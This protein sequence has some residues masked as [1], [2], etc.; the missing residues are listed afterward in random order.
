M[1][2]TGQS[3]HLIG[4][5]KFLQILAFAGAAG[6]L[7]GYGLMRAESQPQVVR[8]SRTL[9]GTQINLIVYGP[10]Q[11]QCLQATAA[12]FNRME[13]LEQV[14]SRHQVNSALSQ[15]NAQGSLMEAPDALLEVLGL[16]DQISRATE[17]AFDVSV[18]PLLQLYEKT[19]V[20]SVV[21]VAEVLPLV[22]YQKIRREGPGIRLAKHG[23]AI[24]L[25]GIAK[26]YIV[27]QG[28]AALRGAGFSNVYVEA[29][30]D[31]MVSGAKP[32]DAPWRIG[33]Q[34]PRPKGAQTMTVL[35]LNTPLAVATS[36]DYM[37]P[38]SEDLR[39]HHILDP[40]KG[41][42]PPELAS[43]T[44]TAPSV[45]LADGLAT[46]SMVL[47]HEKAIELLQQFAGCEGLFID[48]QLNAYK[49]SG[50]QG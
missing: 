6:G 35:E 30:G 17:G 1:S 9:M 19:R 47:G 45:A 49:T 34:N 2:E 32:A 18:L 48:K 11:D 7:Y 27:D 38:F 20:P 31:L 3:R 25:D 41:F 12:T 43:T 13:T 29:G 5:R 37:Q 22:D 23:M 4:R 28:V 10:D 26:G 15:L 14:F 16:A 40:R 33:V 44:V 42:S 24:T 21:E 8:Q 36:G 46:A 39:N 50:F